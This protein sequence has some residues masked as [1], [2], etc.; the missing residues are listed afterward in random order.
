MAVAGV[1]AGRCPQPR[2][3]QP[4]PGRPD[5]RCPGRRSGVVRRGVVGALH[6]RLR[7]RRGTGHAP[8]VLRPDRVLRR[9]CAGRCDA[10]S[11]RGGRPRAALSRPHRRPGH[12]RRQRCRDP[13]GRLHP[14]G[15]A[16]RSRHGRP[17]H[18]GCRRRRRNRG[19][20]RHHRPHGVRLP[21][22]ARRGPVDGHRPPR[23]RPPGARLP[24]H[25][26]RGQLPGRTAGHE[27]VEPPLRRRV[28]RPAG[29]RPARPPAGPVRYER[30]RARGE[31]PRRLLRGPRGTHRGGPVPAARRL[32]PRAR[33]AA[34]Q[35]P[36]PPGPRGLP[37]PV[38]AD[39]HRLLPDP[40]L[41]QRR[42]QR[43]PR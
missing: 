14:A 18:R 28:P 8:V 16:P 2:R 43:P 37:G 25:R 35:R 1:R 9:Q 29:L 7:D 5:V 11:S 4:G 24:G 21:R 13:A 15:P 42:R 26:H 30:H 41:V 12:G 31:D 20:A 19:A 39:L 34:R 6:G 38:D 22:R 32:A 3:H 27:R 10:A 17:G 40:P 36:E 23:V 33:P